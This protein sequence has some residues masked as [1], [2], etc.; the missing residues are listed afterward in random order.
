VLPVVFI[1]LRAEAASLVDRLDLFGVALRSALAVGRILE[2]EGVVSVSGR[3]TL[4]LEQRIEVPEGT[5][6]V[7]VGGHLSKAHLHKDLLELLPH[8]EER[9]QVATV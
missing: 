5:L 3:M 2:E 9:M 7:P 6:H 1:A 8:L 4:R